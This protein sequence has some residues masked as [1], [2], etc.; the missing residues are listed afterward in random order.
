MFYAL[1]AC[2]TLL[3]GVKIFIYVSGC[4]FDVACV[5]RERKSAVFAQAGDPRLGENS[6]NSSLVSA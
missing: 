3:M 5:S 1:D 2:M 6:R 4:L